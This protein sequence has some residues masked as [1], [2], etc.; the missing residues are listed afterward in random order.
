MEI[1]AQKFKKLEKI[2]REMQGFVVAFSGGVD[3]TFLTVLAHKVLKDQ[4]LA[5]TA[6]SQTYPQADLATVKKVIKDFGIRHHFVDTEELADENFLRNPPNRCYH[7]KKELFTKLKA[8]A[9]ANNFTGVADGTNFDDARDFRPGKI[10]ALEEGVRSPLRE[11]RL[12]KDEI[13]VLS[14]RL[15]LVT[16]DKTSSPCLASRFPY[17]VRITAEKISRVRKAEEFLKQ[18][19]FSQVRVRHHEMT[20]RI[21]VSPSEFG[22][23]LLLSRA[24]A[25]VS[26]F[27]ELG[28]NYVTLDL[29]G[30]RTGSLNEVLSAAD[31]K[32]GNT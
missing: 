31:K 27:K 5:V 3:S 6:L 17:G 28:Y 29:E 11:A 13:R 4:V 12:R 24:Q 10:A 30:Y 25:V 1:I 20:A 8:I 7:C 23:L 21:E 9:A 26:K 2:L 14:H 32:F 15:N 16:Y 18:L 22:D 19:G